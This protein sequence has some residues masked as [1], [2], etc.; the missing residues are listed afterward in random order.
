MHDLFACLR[1]TNDRYIAKA[2]SGKNEFAK[3]LV[4]KGI[5]MTSDLGV[6][7]KST[8]LSRGRSDT[9]QYQL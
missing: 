5:I 7:E 1:I 2:C 6:H 9:V 3:I 4:E 8:N